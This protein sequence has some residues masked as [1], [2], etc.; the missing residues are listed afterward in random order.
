[1]PSSCYTYIQYSIPIW[2][3]YVYSTFIDLIIYLQF[4]LEAIKFAGVQ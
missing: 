2:I 3:K 4:Q 1:M